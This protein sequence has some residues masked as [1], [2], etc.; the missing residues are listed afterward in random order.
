MKYSMEA[1]PASI[2]VTWTDE[3]TTYQLA[4]V[5]GTTTL[6]FSMK[7]DGGEWSR[8][9]VITSPERFHDGRPVQTTNDMKAVAEAWFAAGEKAKEKHDG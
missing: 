5:R 4:A 9:A 3:G 6:V 1:T 7:P 8:A 2:G